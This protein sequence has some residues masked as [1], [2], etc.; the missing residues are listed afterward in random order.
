MANEKFYRT[1]VEVVDPAQ[2]RVVARDTLDGWVFSTLPGGRA[3]IYNTTAAEIPYVRII[4]L[5]LTRP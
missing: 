1:I 5:S 2:R 3:A 4:Q